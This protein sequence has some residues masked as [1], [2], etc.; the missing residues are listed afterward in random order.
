MANVLYTIKD[1]DIDIS[2]WIN[3]K[4][5][6]ALSHPDQIYTSLKGYLL[7][8]FLSHVSIE[9]IYYQRI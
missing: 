8:S 3:K 4:K 6:Q 5:Y 7:W 9:D 2:T 1:R